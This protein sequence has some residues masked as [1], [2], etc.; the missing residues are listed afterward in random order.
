MMW[1]VHPELRYQ[2][3]IHLLYRAGGSSGCDV[4]VFSFVAPRSYATF[5]M[6][7]CGERANPP[8]L[9]VPRRC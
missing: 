9:R 1:I 5:L 3:E 8:E 4:F 6:S 7:Q 2:E